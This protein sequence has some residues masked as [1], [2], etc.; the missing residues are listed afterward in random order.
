MDEDVA[1]YSHTGYI[2]WVEVQIIQEIFEKISWSFAINDT[3]AGEAFMQ[4][5]MGH[6]LTF[7]LRCKFLLPELFFRLQIIFP[8][9]LFFSSTLQKAIKGLKGYTNHTCLGLGCLQNVASLH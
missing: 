1:K 9:W 8:F 6:N 7:K 5:M 2:V 3:R 4:I